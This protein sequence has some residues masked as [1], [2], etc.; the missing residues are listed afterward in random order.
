[1]PEPDNFV[2]E[3][4]CGKLFGSLTI[5]VRSVR[6]RNKEFGGNG[7]TVHKGMMR[8]ISVLVVLLFGVLTTIAFAQPVNL[9]FLTGAGGIGNALRPGV[10]VCNQANADTFNVTMVEVPY[11]DLLN[12]EMLQFISG[13]PNFDVFTGASSWWV[14]LQQFVEPLNP[15]IERDGEELVTGLGAQLNSYRLGGEQLGIPVRA[16]VTILYYRKDLLEQ[17]GLDVPTT[18]EELEEAARQLTIDANGDGEPEIY[19]FS[20]TM[21]ERRWVAKHL[22]QLLFGHGYRFLTDDFSAVHPSLTDD[23]V[24]QLM[25]FMRRLTDEGLTPNPLGWNYEDNVLFFQQGRLAMSFEDSV[26]VTLLED[27]E[28]STVLHSWTCTS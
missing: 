4:G 2:Q 23:N 13:Q 3:K 27:P 15:F 26:R 17:A 7:M 24:I 16:G 22:S 25:E 12:Q 5:N 14:A 6:L 10:N 1:M 28:Q 21:G 20:W 11:S 8:S 9:T 19:G 18:L